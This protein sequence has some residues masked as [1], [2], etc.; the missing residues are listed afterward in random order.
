MSATL[1]DG[2]NPH[3]QLVNDYYDDLIAEVDVYAAEILK[4]I[5]D[6]D[7]FLNTHDDDDDDDKVYSMK[8]RI[9]KEEEKFDETTIEKDL[10]QD[11]YNDKYKFEGH[12]ENKEKRLVKDFVRCEQMRAIETLKRAKKERLEELNLVLRTPKTMQETLLGKKFCFCVKLDK[13]SCEMKFGLLIF[14][15][16]FYIEKDQIQFIE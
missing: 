9:K 2:K 10:K 5:K 4:N 8:K 11:P 15:A 14:V 12:M 16:D 13:R 3:G 7:A 6:N 1:I